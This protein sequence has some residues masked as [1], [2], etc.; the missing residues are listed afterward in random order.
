MLGIEVHF[1][2]SA[3]QAG[4]RRLRESV[5]HEMREAARRSSQR[6]AQQARQDHPYQNRT[7]TLERSTIAVPPS[8]SFLAGTLQTAAVGNT[9]YASYL[10][11]RGEFAFLQPAWRAVEGQVDYDL[12]TALGRAAVQAG[13]FLP[14]VDLDGRGVRCAHGVVAP[15]VARNPIPR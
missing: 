2:V 6:L 10:E 11:A 4:I 14:D 8:G 15:D 5:E 1:D 7:G 9:P 3:V 13:V 12:Q